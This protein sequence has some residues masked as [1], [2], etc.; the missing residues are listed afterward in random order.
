MRL[1]PASELSRRLGLA[2]D[3]NLE[4]LQ[5]AQEEPRRV[6]RGDDARAAPKLAQ[7]GRRLRIAADDGPEEHVRVTAQVLRRAVQDEVGAVLERAQVNRRRRGR[8]D[9]HRRRVRGG[10]LEVGHRQEWVRRSLEPDELDA[11][12]RRPGLVELHVLQAPALELAE[13]SRCPVVAAFGDGDRG[14]GLEQSQ[15]DRRRRSCTGGEEECLAAVELPE[16]A[17]GGDAGGVRV[18]LVVELAQL[19]VLVRPERRTVERACLPSSL[20]SPRS[21]PAARGLPESGSSRTLLAGYA[22]RTRRG[23]S[24]DV[25][26][27]HPTITRAARRAGLTSQTMP[28]APRTAVPSDCVSPDTQP[29]ALPALLCRL[30]ASSTTPSGCVWPDVISRIGSRSPRS[31]PSYGLSAI[32]LTIAVRPKCAKAHWRP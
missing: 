3:A 22:E 32:R 6:G 31:P 12:G 9:E 13:E 26:D 19:A 29:S 4:R 23:L 10:G 18:A 7:P 28:R 25:G 15:D 1:E 21:A 14:T 20:R 24:H 27:F 16:D 30:Q 8:V 11:L 17:F 5:P 2:P